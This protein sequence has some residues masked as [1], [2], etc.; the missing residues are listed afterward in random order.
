M[1]R[2]YFTYKKAAV[3]PTQLRCVRQPWRPVSFLFPALVENGSS[4]ADA[5]AV[6]KQKKNEANITN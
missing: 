6:K 3:D 2:I 4:I 1:P 5:V